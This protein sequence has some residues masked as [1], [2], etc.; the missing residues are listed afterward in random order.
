MFVSD[1]LF[2]NFNIHGLL[3][4]FCLTYSLVYSFYANTIFRFI[5]FQFTFFF[6]LVVL[7]YV[8]G[9]EFFATILFLSELV[10]FFYMF[11]LTILRP[12]AVVFPT[13]LHFQLIFIFFFVYS[14]PYYCSFYNYQLW[15]WY[16]CLFSVNNDFYGIFFF[17][18][19]LLVYFIICRCFNDFSYYKFMYFNFIVFF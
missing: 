7:M 2:K 10:V 16:F 13:R 15:D 17:L 6:F 5:T 9:L 4:M 8:Y 19:F 1:I 11:L 12:H 14:F 18:F 3:F